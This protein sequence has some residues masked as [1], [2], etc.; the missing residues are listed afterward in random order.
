[1][2]RFIVNRLGDTNREAQVR[3]VAVLDESGSMQAMRAAAVEGFNQFLAG[4]KSD[5]PQALYSQYTFNS[6]VHTDCVDSKIGETA[7]LGDSYHPNG[8]TALYDAMGTALTTLEACMGPKD[9]A[10]VLIVT[11]G[12]ENASRTFHAQQVRTLVQR[13]EGTGRVTVL[14]VGNVDFGTEQARLLGIS[15]ANIAQNDYRSLRRTKA[16]YGSGLLGSTQ[17]A[18][19][20]MGVTKTG[21]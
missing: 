19:N 21:G 16:A 15:L 1:M 3:V 4:A 2:E 6:R 18:F 7:P 12:Q 13:M 17:S 5:Y 14:Y 9:K 20:N 11:D 10:V 8:N